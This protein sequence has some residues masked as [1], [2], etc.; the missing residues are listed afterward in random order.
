M[1]KQPIERRKKGI[2]LLP[3]LFTVAAMFAGFYAIVAST[4]HAFEAAS[5]AIFV[6]MLLDGLDG[7]IARMTHTQ[8]EFGAQFDSLS[9]ML[10]FGITPALVVYGWSLQSLGKTG[11]LVAFLYAV[12]TAM[13]LA[14]FNAQVQQVNKRYFQGLATPAAAGTVASLIWS[15]TKHGIA[16]TS[17][18]IVVF[19]VV[20]LLALLKVSRIRYRSFKDLD[21]RGRIPF[22]AILMI[23][24]VFVLISYDPPDMLLLIF[25]L[26]VLSGPLMTIW[27]LH[28]KRKLRY[29]SDD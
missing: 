2:Y 16:G 23:V 7:R 21:V 9:D 19:A 18:S 26:Y 20:V 1:S 29:K 6:A 15:C 22:L 28:K 11:W 17:I 10:C 13:R 3:N 14:R 25:S 12:C 24:L 4:K 27:Q 5:I 8:T